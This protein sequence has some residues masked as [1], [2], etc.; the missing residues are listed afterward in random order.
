M[1]NKTARLMCRLTNEFYKRNADSFSQTRAGAWSGW[2]TLADILRA[3]K[4]DTLTSQIS[5]LDLACG[6]MRFLDFL[7][8]EFADEIGENT[9]LDYFAV[10]NCDALVHARTIQATSA[11]IHFHN[12]DITRALFDK[13]EPSSLIDI[14]GCSLAVCFGFMHHVPLPEHRLRVL[15]ALIDALEP[16]GFVAVSFWRF[17]TDEKFAKKARS[18]HEQAMS[19]LRQLAQNERTGGKLTSGE[20]LGAALVPNEHALYEPAFGELSLDEG[21]FLLG[22]NGQSHTFRYCHS[23]SE[24]E[25]DTLVGRISPRANE[26]ARFRADG[27]THEMN[28]YLVLQRV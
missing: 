18:E 7:M 12:T 28:T 27:R 26:I 22:W 11:A 1:D 19:E 9:R 23:F 14:S 10:D 4:F 2:K 24:E 15:N 20:C 8:H 5:V 16:G 6:N 25:I 13:K 3:H 17:M 21:D